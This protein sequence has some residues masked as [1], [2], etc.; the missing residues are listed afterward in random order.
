MKQGNQNQ[1]ESQDETDI[2]RAFDDLRI[3]TEKERQRL[4]RLQDLGEQRKPSTETYIIRLS[5]TSADDLA[6]P[7]AESSNLFLD[8]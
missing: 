2:Q 7:K 8:A 1:A 4:R 6:S 5:N 3:A